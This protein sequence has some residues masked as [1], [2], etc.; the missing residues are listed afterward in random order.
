MHCH[1]ESNPIKNC[2]SSSKIWD[3]NTSW[4]ERPIVTTRS[5]TKPDNSEWAKIN[6][7]GL[8]K[9]VDGEYIDVPRTD[10]SDSCYDKGLIGPGC[11]YSNGKWK[12]DDLCKFT[13]ILIFMS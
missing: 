8:Y 4:L 6:L 9:I 7:P 10:Y 13:K 3:P 5:G 1:S 11:D 12:C 2:F